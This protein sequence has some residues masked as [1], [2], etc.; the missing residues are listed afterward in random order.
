MIICFTSSL[1]AGDYRVGWKAG[2]G[3]TTVLSN[4][5]DHM[6]DWDFKFG[7]MF[8]GTFIFNL[9]KLLDYESDILFANKGFITKDELKLSLNYL[10]FPQL[11][12]FRLFKTNFYVVGGF[13]VNFLLGAERI[14]NQGN[15]VNYN[16]YLKAVDFDMVFGGGYSFYLASRTSM[17]IELRYEKGFT[18]ISKD[19]DFFRNAIN[20]NIGYY[21]I[22][23]MNFG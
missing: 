16:E 18:D 14:D 12:N 6:E 9:Y 1:N 21:F 7:L 13:A 4:Y 5:E 23:G 19:S 8:G 20:E 22:L 3:L 15:S 11:L 17:V 10:S 2:G